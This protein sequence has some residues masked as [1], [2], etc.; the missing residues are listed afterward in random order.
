MANTPAVQDLSQQQQIVTR[1]GQKGE[2]EA[3]GADYKNVS[4]PL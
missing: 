2:V 3:N 1:P 4:L